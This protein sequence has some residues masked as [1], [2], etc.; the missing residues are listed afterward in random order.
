MIKRNNFDIFTKVFKRS[1][2]TKTTLNP[3]KINLVQPD[4]EHKSLIL[5]TTPPQLNNIVN[6]LYNNKIFENFKL[7]QILV[8]CID[9]I[10]NSRNG[11]SELWSKNEFELK[12]YETIEDRDKRIMKRNDPL[13]VN[14]I[15]LDKNWNDIKE[16]TLFEINFNE[17]KLN[18]KLKL[19]NTLFANNEN[20]TCFYIGNKSIDWFNLASIQIDIKLDNFNKIN[21]IDYFNRLTEIPLIEDIEK[22]DDYY[23]ITD[24]E[25]NLIKSINDRSASG[26]LTNNSIVMSSKK[27]LYFKLYNHQTEKDIKPYQQ[28]FYK[29]LVGGLGWGE[30]QAF[31]AIDPI[32]GKAGYRDVKLFYYDKNSKQFNIELPK[33]FMNNKLIFECSELE[34][35]YETYNLHQTDSQT[36]IKP[37]IFAMGCEN[38]F[39]LNNIWHGSNGEFIDVEVGNK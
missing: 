2:F 23:T 21:S 5:L 39:Q 13:S 7:N 28:E 25:G 31:L 3:D 15:K 8:V 16:H 26:Y 32:V 36:V 6:N 24:F 1:L 30:K 27:N 22:R 35:I 9:S 12:N 33:Q 4:N 38:G 29:L 19:A 18:S 37:G 17:I 14:P 20:S 34:Q 10:L 11:Y